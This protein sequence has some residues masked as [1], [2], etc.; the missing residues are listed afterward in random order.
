MIYL[1]AMEEDIKI[2][3]RH[4]FNTLFIFHYNTLRRLLSPS[5]RLIYFYMFLPALA[6]A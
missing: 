3:G 4:H 1:N 5:K 6:I 2:E